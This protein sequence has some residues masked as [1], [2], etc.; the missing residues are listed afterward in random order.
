M[1]AKA[2][3]TRREPRGDIQRARERERGETRTTRE[4]RRNN[5]GRET[6][7]RER[8]SEMAVQQ[9][10]G[11]ERGGER[12]NYRMVMAFSAPPPLDLPDLSMLQKKRAQYQFGT[13][14]EASQGKENALVDAEEV[15]A[16]ELVQRDLVVYR[17]I[18]RPSSASSQPER[19]ERKSAHRP[20]CNSAA[21]T[22]R[23]R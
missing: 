20:R 15:S 10:K 14:E 1:K 23:C 18:P 8:E 16:G 19:E 4:R 13:P 2:S 5:D 12:G 3:E 9:G 17:S 11:N 21:C 6:L 22:R 7:G